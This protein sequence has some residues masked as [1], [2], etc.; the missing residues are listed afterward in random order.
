MT[1][2]DLQA[3][4]QKQPAVQFHL[5]SDLLLTEVRR[6]QQSFVS[7]VFWRDFRECAVGAFMTYYFGEIAL[8]QHHWIFY[9]QAVTCLFVTLFILIDR[10]RQRRKA[11]PIIETLQHYAEQSLRDVQHQ[12]WLLSNVLWWYLLPIAVPM[13]LFFALRGSS[14]TRSFT[15]LLVAGI[16]NVYIYRLNQRFVRTH[17]LPRAQELEKL[18][19]TLSAES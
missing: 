8:R 4:W 17:L 7:A 10:H 2:D 14:L 3:T 5:R 6:N 15:L 1:F 13:F 11:P 9:F 16:L 12:I 18:L 19:A